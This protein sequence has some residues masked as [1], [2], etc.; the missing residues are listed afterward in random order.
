MKVFSSKIVYIL[1][2]LTGMIHIGCGGKKTLS[3]EQYIEW[4]NDKNNGLINVQEIG[5]YKFQLQYQPA[6]YLAVC[7]MIS[8][9]NDM[10]RANFDS[11]Y[12]QYKGMQYCLL[13][14]GSAT[15]G[16]DF[17]K[18]SISTEQ[19]YFDRIQYFTSYVQHDMFLLEPNDTQTCSMHHFERSYS[20]NSFNTILLAF[21][22]KGNPGQKELL[23]NDQVLGIGKIRFTIPEKSLSRIP[24]IE[25]L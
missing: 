15:K 19:E 4:M 24:S 18:Q 16:E 12:A 5:G 10:T 25:L 22:N 13:K 11:V 9:G 6:E 2:A 8:E 20:L 1:I 23:F 21:P 14:I 7:E 3:P 17:L